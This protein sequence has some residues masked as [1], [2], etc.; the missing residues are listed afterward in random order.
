[1]SRLIAMVCN[2]PDRLRCVLAP[3][4]ASLR[5]DPDPVTQ[6]R[7]FDAWGIGLYQGG[8]VLLKRRPQPTL[9]P[10]DFFAIAAE[11]R[12]DTL[13]AHA[14]SATVGDN[15][16]ENTH[17]FRFRS[18]LFAHHG[19]LP[20]FGPLHGSTDPAR[21]TP[22][23]AALTETLLADLPDFI[24]RNLRGQT[25]SELLFHLFLTRLHEAAHLDVADLRVA[26]AQ[27][28]LVRTIERLDEMLRARGLDPRMLGVLVLANGRFLM[29][30][31]RGMPLYA[32]HVDGMKDCAVCREKRTHERPRAID[33]D[34]LRAVLLVADAPQPLTAPFRTVADGTLLTISRDLTVTEALLGSGV[35]PRV[36]PS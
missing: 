1:M 11:L 24:R 5:A 18:W 21:P 22:E 31:N 32:M 16:N 26:D 9:G 29:A 2:D 28:A 17:P 12:T 27:A 13:I 36:L 20:G 15:R 25:D 19:T 14:R 23:Q 6:A 7:G 33:H 10:V 3:V 8:E 35:A 4:Q 30:V 34:H